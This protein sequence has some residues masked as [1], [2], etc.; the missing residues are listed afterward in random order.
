[1]GVL[2]QQEI[3]VSQ[4]PAFGKF[5]LFLSH[6]PVKDITPSYVDHPPALAGHQV[7]ER[8]RDIYISLFH[9]IFTKK[10]EKVKTK[11]KAEMTIIPEKV[12]NIIIYVQIV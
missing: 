3:Q 11:K 7:P 5:G 12:V 2:P 10:P 4:L 8:K 1:M 9:L 6:D